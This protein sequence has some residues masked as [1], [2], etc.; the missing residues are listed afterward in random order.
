MELIK[1]SGVPL[2]P[3]W[4]VANVTVNQMHDPM[5]SKKTA[6]V[7]KPSHRA[8]YICHVMTGI[9]GAAVWAQ[10]QARKFGSLSS[11]QTNEKKRAPKYSTSLKRFAVPR[12]PTKFKAMLVILVT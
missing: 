4:N 10:I 1:I 5:L 11:H 7:T 3:Q 8:S 2:Q 12:L 6:I 9:V